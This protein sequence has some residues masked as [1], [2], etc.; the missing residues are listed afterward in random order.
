MSSNRNI[1]FDHRTTLRASLACSSGIYSYY[2]STSILSF[3]GQKLNQCRP[4][5]IRDTFGISFLLN[6]ALNIKSFMRDEIVF[7]NELVGSLVA[8]VFSSVFNSFV[9]FG[10]NHLMF[11]FKGDIFPTLGLS[12]SPLLLFEKSWLVY[13]RAIGALNICNEPKINSSYLTCLWKR[14]WLFNFTREIHKPFFGRSSFDSACF[15]NSF[16]RSMENSFYSTNLRKIC[17]TGMNPKP[18]LRIGN[19]AVSSIS[20]KSWKSRILSMLATPEKCFESQVYS[21]LGILKNLALNIFKFRFL[22]FPLCQFVGS[23]IKRNISLF[24]F[25]SILSKCK[26]LI[27]YPASLLQDVIHF[28]NLKFGWV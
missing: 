18:G 3:V 19:G 10:Q 22:R 6:H 21:K 11:S 16:D 26:G 25:P 13:F 20:P 28:G 1:F 24:R 5:S 4:R 15:N 7:I 14:F 8:E 9:N 12:K 2:D 17:F 27:I 23:I